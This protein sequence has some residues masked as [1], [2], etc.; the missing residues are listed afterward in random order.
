MG[1]SGSDNVT[2]TLP[3]PGKAKV[4]VEEHSDKPKKLRGTVNPDNNESVG[5]VWTPDTSMSSY[6]GKKFNIKIFTL[7]GELVEEFSKMPQAAD[8]TWIKWTPKDIASGIYIV[9]I[10]G[11]G[12][13]IKKKVAVLR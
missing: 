12:I 7:K 11:P 5:I 4:I 9:Y 1:N 2:L 6:I 10:K 13:E 8:D 3:S